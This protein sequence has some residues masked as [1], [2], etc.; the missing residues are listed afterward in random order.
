MTCRAVPPGVVQLLSPPIDPNISGILAVYRLES[1]LFLH[2]ASVPRWL[3]QCL[4]KQVAE[5]DHLPLRSELIIYGI[6]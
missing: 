6:L 5:V 1:D 2:G 3:L 4:G